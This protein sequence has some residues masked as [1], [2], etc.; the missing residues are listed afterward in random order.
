MHSKVA[1]CL[2]PH[3]TNVA[4]AFL[5]LGQRFDLHGV[6]KPSYAFVEPI[7]AWVRR[8]LF[9]LV[10]KHDT[11]NMIKTPASRQATLVSL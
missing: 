3:S 11:K 7:M 10:H 2:G 9:T 1:Y 8:Q 5:V 6:Y 4:L